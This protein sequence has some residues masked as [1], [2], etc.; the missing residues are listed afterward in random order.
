MKKSICLLLTTYLVSACTWVSLDE[1]GQGVRLID[2]D[3]AS[4]CKKIGSTSSRVVDNVGPL[5][6]NKKKMGKELIRLAKNEAGVMGGN[7]ITP[8]AEA[9]DGTQKFAVY[10]C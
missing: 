4:Q 10:D 5:P 6:R 8:L 7:A 9:S 1:N 2:A 3:T